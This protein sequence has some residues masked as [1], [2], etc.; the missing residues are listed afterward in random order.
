[1]PPPLHDIRQWVVW[2]E[3]YVK[4][5]ICATRNKGNWVEEKN[6]FDWKEGGGGVIYVKLSEAPKRIWFEEI[7]VMVFILREDHSYSKIIF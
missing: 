2:I 6:I 4:M 1:M 3:D 5:W 7:V